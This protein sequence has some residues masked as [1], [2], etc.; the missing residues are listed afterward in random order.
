M[1]AC[2]FHTVGAGWTGRM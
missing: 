2:S 1:S